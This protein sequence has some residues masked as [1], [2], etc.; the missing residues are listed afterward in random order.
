MPQRR[1]R[2]PGQGHPCDP[3]ERG[4]PTTNPPPSPPPTST[5]P[6]LPDRAR[7][8]LGPGRQCHPPS[9]AAPDRS[10]T[11]EA[12][13]AKAATSSIPGHGWSHDP[14]PNALVENHDRPG[15]DGE[16]RDQQPDLNIQRSGLDFR[17]EDGLQ[18]GWWKKWPTCQPDGPRPRQSSRSGRPAVGGPPLVEAV[19]G[20]DDEKRRQIPPLLPEVPPAIK[21]PR[22]PST[23]SLTATARTASRLRLSSSLSRRR[24]VASVSSRTTRQCGLDWLVQG[25]VVGMDPPGS[26]RP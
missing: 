23:T 10:I 15:G 26:W 18:A 1:R 13:E 25:L 12:E 9:S 3:S 5:P 14:V 16:S 19:V 22:R 11:V 21:P 4:L 6:P 7:D 24:R 20:G 17:V 8:R 2:R